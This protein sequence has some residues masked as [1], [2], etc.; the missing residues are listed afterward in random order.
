M[1]AYFPEELIFTEIL[2]RLPLKSL[3][4]FRCVSKSWKAQIDNPQFVK[5]HYDRTKNSDSAEVRILVG[6]SHR[7]TY[8]LYSIDVHGSLCLDLDE[9]S[10]KA[11]KIEI[12][13]KLR[14]NVYERD[15]YYGCQILGSCNGLICLGLLFK[16]APLA[17]AFVNPL[18]QKH[19]D[20]PRFPK[21][22]FEGTCYEYGFG[23]NEVTDDYMMI[24]LVGNP[25]T[26]VTIYS[27]K[28][29]SWRRVLDS[30]FQG[31]KGT[32]D[33]RI[34][35]FA[36][37][38][39]HWVMRDW[40]PPMANFI[41]AFDLQTEKFYPIA[42]PKYLSGTVLWRIILGNLGGCLS[43]VFH[44][45]FETSVV[46][47]WMMKN[48]GVGDSWIKFILKL[49]IYGRYMSVIP[50][51]FLKG[52][53]RQV[54]LEIHTNCFTIKSNYLLLYNLDTRSAFFI[55][56][57]VAFSSS[58]ACVCSGSLLRPSTGGRRMLSIRWSWPLWNGNRSMEEFADYIAALACQR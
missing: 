8:K 31:M 46:E 45:R 58:M 7:G 3:A 41:A 56:N 54:L 40:E 28:S 30:P 26:T 35:V 37:K 22:C 48:Y 5:M 44:S 14:H 52:Y 55:R 20:L 33:Q 21:H 39:V 38:A 4:Q 6:G 1:S 47:L 23:Y 16:T 36:G 24:V 15:G 18:T 17:L 10:E 13:R 50:V 43:V 53:H 2:I 29:N 42:L 25:P 27:L 12:P 32:I 49:P 11:K 19:W 34:G 51:A 57:P 9:S